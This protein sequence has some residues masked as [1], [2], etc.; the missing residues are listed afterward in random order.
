MMLRRVLVAKN[1]RAALRAGGRFAVCVWGAAEEVP[2]I[3]LGPRVIRSVLD[4][5]PVDPEEPG[6]FRLADPDELRGVLAEGGFS[7]VEVEERRVTLAFAGPA[8]YVEFVCDLSST[9]RKCIAPL[10]EEERGRVL[11]ELEA[12][13]AAFRVEDGTVR[14]DNR[15]LCAVG[16]VS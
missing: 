10:H 12:A 6:P 4:V 13:T 7:D 15:V 5:A 2:F 16:T 11:G 1:V 8:E 3:A 14:F 9:F